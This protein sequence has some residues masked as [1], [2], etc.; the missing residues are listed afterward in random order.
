MERFITV[1]RFRLFVAVVTALVLA[2]M[3][4]PY[5]GAAYTEYVGQ[6]N[7]ADINGV[8][9]VQAD[10][11]F[12]YMMNEMYPEGS[13]YMSTDISDVAVIEANFGGNWEAWGQGKVPVGMGG[14]LPVGS[15]GGSANAAVNMTGL[16][17]TLPALTAGGLSLLDQGSVSWSGSVAWSGSYSYDA[18][19]NKTLSVD[20][21][22]QHNHDVS[23]RTIMGHSSRSKGNGANFNSDRNVGD[24]GGGTN[25]GST[26]DPATG[27]TTSYAYVEVGPTGD[28][29]SFPVNTSFSLSG[30]DLG[31][32]INGS[33]GSLG[34]PSINSGGSHQTVTDNSLT[35][36]GSGTATVT[37]NT[38]QPYITCYMY[39]RTALASYN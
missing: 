3:L 13:I 32:S 18:E 16:P 38:V 10:N 25:Y 14:S 34:T 24:Y 27:A 4:A 29:E 28:G 20:E 37:D 6:F 12:I 23:S 15:V 39:K 35:A 21:M 26:Y 9:V 36:G 5:A 33:T 8:T 22:P 30:A 11:L 17:V 7:H 31:P 19:Y 1:K 2:A